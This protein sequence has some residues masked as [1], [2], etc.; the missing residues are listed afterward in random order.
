ML[1]LLLQIGDAP[2]AID[3]R[4]IEAVVPWVRLGPAPDA[5]AWCRGRLR[6]RGA[7]LPV[8]DLS[9]LAGHG[10]CAARWSTR[11]IILRTPAGRLGLLA[12]RVTD[13][14]RDPVGES[15]PHRIRLERLLPPEI[16]RLCAAPP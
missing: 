10:P 11:I 5:P 2:C 15:A 8:V 12:E 9:S 4:E 14:V 3:S 6:Y 16:L 7:L 13:A 1:H